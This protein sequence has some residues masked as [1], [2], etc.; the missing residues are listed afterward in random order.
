MRLCSVSVGMGLHTGQVTTPPPWVM[1]WERKGKSSG[2]DYWTGWTRLDWTVGHHVWFD[3]GK[4]RT[5]R[6]SSFYG[7]CVGESGAGAWTN[8]LTS[9]P[10]LPFPLL[11]STLSQRPPPPSLLFSHL[12]LLRQNC[13]SLEYIDCLTYFAPTTSLE[14]LRD[15]S[16]SGNRTLLFVYVARIVHK[17]ALLCTKTFRLFHM[18]IVCLCRGPVA[19]YVH[20]FVSSLLDCTSLRPIICAP[21]DSLLIHDIR[22]SILEQTFT[23]NHFGISTCTPH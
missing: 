20:T 17:D 18:N 12:V 6:M 15:A 3:P 10:P 2:F 13:A 16:T 9:L 5:V 23:W 14:Q 22:T 19:L 21:H 1:W 8:R 4:E 7:G 11:L